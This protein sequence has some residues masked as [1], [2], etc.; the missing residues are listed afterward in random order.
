MIPL[1]KIAEYFAVLEVLAAFHPKP[2]NSWS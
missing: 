1:R 2:S